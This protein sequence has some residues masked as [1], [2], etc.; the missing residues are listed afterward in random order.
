MIININYNKMRVSLFNKVVNIIQITKSF[1]IDEI[2]VIAEGI[3]RFDVCVTTFNLFY[4]IIKIGL[5]ES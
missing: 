4:L 1:L 2:N 3:A 5:S